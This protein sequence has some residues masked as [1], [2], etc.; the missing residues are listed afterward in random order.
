MSKVIHLK[1]QD[2]EVKSDNT[3][4]SYKAKPFKTNSSNNSDPT[5]ASKISGLPVLLK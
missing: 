1:L 2:I 3:V 5:I 4:S